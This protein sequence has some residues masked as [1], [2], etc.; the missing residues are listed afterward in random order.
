MEARHC[1]FCAESG[2]SGSVTSL[3][4]MVCTA[5][6]TVAPAAPVPC[7]SR[8]RILATKSA[9]NREHQKLR[10]ARQKIRQPLWKHRPTERL[11]H[12]CTLSIGRVVWRSTSHSLRRMPHVD[13]GDMH[14][15]DKD[16]CACCLCD[17]VTPLVNKCATFSP[18][19]HCTLRTVGCVRWMNVFELI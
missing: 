12:S 4:L 11:P 19:A 13:E 7:N 9:R 15:A 6:A 1:R 14:Q 2:A 5:S 10:H 8:Y 3:L 16:F 17:H 18:S